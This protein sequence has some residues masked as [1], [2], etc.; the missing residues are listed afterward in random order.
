MTYLPAMLH[1][2]IIIF[3]ASATFSEGIS[4]PRSPRATMTPSVYL[5]IS[6][7]LRMPSS[8][9]ILEMIWISRPPFSSR[10][11]R[12]VKTSS[13]DCTKETAMKSILF[14]HAKFLMSST[15]LGWSTSSSTLTPGRLPFLRSPSFLS[16]MTTPLRWRSSRIS[17]TL[18]TTEPSAKRS[19]FPGCTD[20]HSLAYEHPILVS[21]SVLYPSKVVYSSGPAA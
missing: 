13:P 14:L 9:S 21:S 20:W 15:S 1:L 12:T 17:V 10:I 18:I 19:L 8:F 3:C 4:M 6:S 7:K 5:R 16:F 11:L 2:V